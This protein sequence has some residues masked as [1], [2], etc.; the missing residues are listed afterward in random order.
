MTDGLSLLELSDLPATWRAIIRLL[1]RRQPQTYAT[2]SAALAEQSSQPMS[3]EQLQATLADLCR[4]GYVVQQTVEGD[5]TFQMH[6]ARKSGRSASSS[7]WNALEPGATTD[8]KPTESA[9]LRRPRK[10][11]WESLG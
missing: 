8:A 10:N 6:I 5:P 11:L 9:P 2:L 7:L 3:G 4:E 1:M